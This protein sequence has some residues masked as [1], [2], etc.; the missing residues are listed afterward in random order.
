MAYTAGNIAK[1]RSQNYLNEKLSC[2]ADYNIWELYTYLLKRLDDEYGLSPAK[3]AE[4]LD[5]LFFALRGV[6]VQPLDE[7]RKNI[8][9]F[10]KCISIGNTQ[11]WRNIGLTFVERL[12]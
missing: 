12:A 4:M 5:M 6:N 3:S 2:V 1:E 11:S 9:R 8:A 7:A 10:Q